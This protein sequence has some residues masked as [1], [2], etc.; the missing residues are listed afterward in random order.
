MKNQI[1]SQVLL[2]TKCFLVGA[3]EI[4]VLSLS[5]SSYATTAADYRALG[6]RY[7]QQGQ[8]DAAIAALTQAVALEPD[9][10]D[11][12]IALGWT[13]HLA[14]QRQAAAQ[15]LTAVAWADPYKVQAFNALGIVYLVSGDL[16]LAIASHMWA[17]LLKPDNEIAYYNLSLACQRIQSY[18]W[19]I[20]TAMRAAELEP[21]NPHPLIALALA[22]WSQGNRAAAQA[23]YTQALALDDRY[24]DLG[25]LAYLAEAGFSADQIEVTQ[26]ILKSR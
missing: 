11:G 15:T 6:L 16:A 4:A 23:A 17:L 19:A 26:Q 8:L 12:R 5:Q 9:N 7:R 1:A 25:F 18:D 3:L 20:V 13:Q 2:L 14:A 22:H 21:T 10:L 24:G